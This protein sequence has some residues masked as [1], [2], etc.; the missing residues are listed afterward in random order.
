MSITSTLVDRAE[1]RFHEAAEVL[2]PYVGCFWVV[3][4]ERNATIRVVPDGSTS[5]S[6]QLQNGE[7]SGWVLRGPLL[8]PDERR[9][10][11]PATSSA[12]ECD[13]ASR[14]S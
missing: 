2:Q 10:L 9:F 6:I 13:L 3:T 7:S 4:A 5:I 12:C 14:S 11:S 1:I 8:C